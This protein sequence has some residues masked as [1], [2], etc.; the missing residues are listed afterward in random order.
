LAPQLEP[1]Y[2]VAVETHTYIS[3]APTQAIRSRYPDANVLRIGDAAPADSNLPTAPLP[4]ARDPL[5]DLGAVLHDLYTI[6]P[7]TSW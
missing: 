7:A 4:G 6:A 5:V 1:R 3:A 2:F